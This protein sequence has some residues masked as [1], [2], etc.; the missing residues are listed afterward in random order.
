MENSIAVHIIHG[1]QGASL[2]NAK[3][4]VLL[5]GYLHAAAGHNTP[6]ELLLDQH[7]KDVDKTLASLSRIAWGPHDTMAVLKNVKSNR[8]FAERMDDT[9]G[10]VVRQV[11]KIPLH[12]VGLRS[13]VGL[14]QDKAYGN[15]GL[16]IVR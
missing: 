1:F 9:T 12:R 3:V 10:K 2:V 15:G 6:L 7:F 13:D 5:M 16:W 11:D 4:K 14:M 8:T